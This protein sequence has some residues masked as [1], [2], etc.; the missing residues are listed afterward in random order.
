MDS[1]QL[2]RLET[3]TTQPNSPKRKA[4]IVGVQR[5]SVGGLQVELQGPH[6]DAAKIRDLLIGVYHY[7]DVTMI[8]DDGDPS[9]DATQ[10]T[11]KN[12]IEHIKTLTQGI[13]SGDYLFFYFSGHATQRKVLINGDE[14]DGMDECE[15]FDILSLLMFNT[16]G[17]TLRKYLSDNLPE[18]CHLTVV[19][20]TCHSGTLLD[21]AHHRCNRVVG[22]RRSN[23]WEISSTYTVNLPSEGQVQYRNSV[24]IFNNTFQTS[25]GTALGSHG[26]YESPLSEMFCNGCCEISK[27]SKKANVVC[28]SSCKDSQSTG[29]MDDE[30]S[31]TNRNPHGLTLK[32]LMVQ[33]TQETE[34]TISRPQRRKQSYS[35]QVQSWCEKFFKAGKPITSSEKHK[36]LDFLRQ[37]F[38]Q[39]PQLPSEP[40]PIDMPNGF[41]DP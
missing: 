20:N 39:D 26:S 21:L 37:N 15:S 18:G 11:Y 5:S 28:L 6:R 25:I 10:P 27:Y 32:D 40:S 31:M 17:Q 3:G 16:N 30:W 24:L 41:W 14:E 13:Q 23:S 34:K 2:S 1:I 12:L 29:E 38:K 8:L 35:I 4:L 33:I 19:L 36:I 22:P 9:H 7:T